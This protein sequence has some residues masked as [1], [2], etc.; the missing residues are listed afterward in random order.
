VRWTWG[1]V[2]AYGLG[3]GVLLLMIAAILYRSARHRAQVRLLTLVL[4]V[5]GCAFAFCA[6]LMYLTGSATATYDLQVVGLLFFWAGPAAYLLFIGT[7]PSPLARPLRSPAGR[8]VLTLLLI[9][10]PLVFVLRRHSMI[11]SVVPGTYSPWDVE[12]GNGILLWLPALLLLTCLYGLIAGVDAFRR[13]PRGSEQRRQ[14]RYFIVAF[15]VR[16]LAQMVNYG[17]IV[18]LTLGIHLAWATLMLYFVLLVP[19]TVELVWALL[20]SYAVL[21]AHLFDVDLKVK[22]A[23]RGTTLTSFFIVAFLIVSQLVQN[24]TSQFFGYMGGA[25]AA[26]LLLFALHPLQ[27]AADR[28]ANAAMPRVK[29]TPDYIDARKA[30]VY[31]AALEGGLQDGTITATERAM[32]T[33]LQ[34]ELG[35]ANADARALEA[36]VRTVMGL[37]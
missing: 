10:M 17:L 34:L 28:M 25:V 14:M 30:A 27:R 20:L 31:S 37:T 19:V 2:G 8:V 11:L 21:R 33:A 35:I 23:L 3:V 29:E 15:G 18:A 22:F 24:I 36:R 26:G 5:E 4:V 7:L 16:D 13:A 9:G 12:F 1:P 6:G 32:L